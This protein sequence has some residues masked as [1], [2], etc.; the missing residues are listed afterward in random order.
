MVAITITGSIK[1]G[2]SWDALQTVVRSMVGDD[3]GVLV[4]IARRDGGVNYRATAGVYDVTFRTAG[5]E[6]P[7]TLTVNS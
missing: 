5:E 7:V 4:R 2:P 3:E 6:I 1:F